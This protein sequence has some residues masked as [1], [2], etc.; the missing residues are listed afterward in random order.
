MINSCVLFGGTTEG[1]EIAEIFAGTPLRMDVFVAT[2]Y[3]ASLLPVSPNLTV[4]AGRKDAGQ[5]EAVLRERKPGL[6]VDATHPYACIITKELRA[7][8]ERLGT[9]FLRVRRASLSEHAAAGAPPLHTAANMADAV[10]FL[11]GTEGPVLVTTGSKEVHLLSG[12]R[13][14]QE[15]C[16]VRVLPSVRSISL[17]EAAGLSGR[18]VIAM[19]GPF[20]EEANEVLMRDLGIRWMLTK[21]SGEEGGCPEKCRAAASLGVG[22]VLIGR[23]EEDAGAV[24]LREAADRI[25]RMAGLRPEA[26]SVP[27]QAEPER[28]NGGPADAEHGEPRADDTAFVQEVGLVGMGPG[29]EGLLTGE[30]LSFILSADLLVGADRMLSEACAIRRRHGLDGD[31]GPRCISACLASEIADRLKADHIFRRAALLYSGDIS[32]YS[33]AKKIPPLLPPSMRVLHFSGIS[34]IG[35]FLGRLGAAEEDTAVVSI[36]GRKA[37]LLP[38]IRSRE[39]VLTLIGEED[40]VSRIAGSLAEAGLGDVRITV[41]TDL[42]YTDGNEPSP[43]LEAGQSEADDRA[44]ESGEP[45]QAEGAPFRRERILTGR[46]ENFIGRKV[47]RLSLVH[48]RNPHPV[49]APAG[50]GLPDDA[51][52][53]ARVPMTK[54]EIRTL[55]LSHLRLSEKDVV[56][57]IGAGTGSVSVEAAL[58]VPKGTVYAVER[59]AEAVRLIRANREKFG[60]ENLEVVEGTAPEAMAGLP[61]A[62]AAFIGGSGGGLKEIVSLVLAGNPEARI[63][64]NSVTSETDAELEEVRRL[65]P[66]KTFEKLE[67]MVVRER[68]AGRYHLKTPDS[69]ITIVTI[70]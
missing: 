22:T 11:D 6:C 32:R 57:D 25:A 30:A 44:G 63:V 49:P 26:R 51:F 15:R 12:I 24:T 38:L 53:R 58:H 41:G 2:E 48:F 64:I 39:S 50:F 20:S 18:H 65:F 7:V 52:I 23:P 4:H 62:D 3:G 16:F 37:N 9:P 35:Y 40:D 66:Q 67:V 33:G 28:M 1:R 70:G 69:P 59:G 46:P 8:C 5:I 56:Y 55:S 43:V 47:G 17:C 34:S 68:A 31:G 60:L 29:R 14:F 27:E 45:E 36:H 21:D 13:D 19:Q 61:P 42:S 10:R 54:K